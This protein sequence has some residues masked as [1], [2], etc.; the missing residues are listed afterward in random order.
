MIALGAEVTPSPGGV[1]GG[2]PKIT[3]SPSTLR[4]SYDAS[5]YYDDAPNKDADADGGGTAAEAQLERELAAALARAAA[6]ERRCDRLAAALR[7][8][9]DAAAGALEE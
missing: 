4:R 1:G 6:A 3:R 9:R 8:A 5:Q 7:D 2:S